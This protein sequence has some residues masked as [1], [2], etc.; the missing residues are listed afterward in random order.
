MGRMKDLYT[1]AQTYIEIGHQIEALE[2]ERKAIKER[3]GGVLEVGSEVVYKGIRY[4]WEQYERR[5][6][7]WKGLYKAA[8]MLLDDEAMVI[9]GEKE[10]KATKKS[11]PFYKFVAKD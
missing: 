3:L 5:S 7:S 11:G 6:T 9:M 8:Y 1:E 2:G 10:R 4:V